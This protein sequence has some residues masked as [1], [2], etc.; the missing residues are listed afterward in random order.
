LLSLE[1]RKLEQL[2]ADRWPGAL[3]DGRHDAAER[4]R[5]LIELE[6]LLVEHLEEHGDRAPPAG[7][8]PV[9][10]VLARAARFIEP[11]VAPFRV[12][13]I[14][15][16]RAPGQLVRYPRDFAIVARRVVAQTLLRPLVFYAIV[17]TL[18]GYTVLFVISKVGGAG[19]R[20]DAPLRQ[21]G[22]S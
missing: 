14:A 12:A 19:V 17:S 6:T 21:I 4:G 10:S 8:P 13:M 18:I 3:E 1:D 22:G 9:Q 11:V 5:W 20:P 16:T 15:A 2:F 7:T